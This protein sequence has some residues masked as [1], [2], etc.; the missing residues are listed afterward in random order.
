MGKGS[1]IVTPVAQVAAVAQ[2]QSLAGPETSACHRH[3]HVFNSSSCNLIFIMEVQLLL[4]L[5]IRTWVKSLK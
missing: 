2:V 3:G 5:N 1:S 4:S